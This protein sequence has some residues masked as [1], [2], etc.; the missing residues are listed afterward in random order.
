M[1]ESIKMLPCCSKKKKKR[2]G[3]E[4]KGA[5]SSILLS[6]P[7]I[8][9]QRMTRRSHVMAFRKARR[10]YRA[11]RKE[12][13]EKTKLLRKLYRERKARELARE[14]ARRVGREMAA[15]LLVE[16]LIREGSF[17][18]E[19]WDS[20]RTDGG[21]EFTDLI[22]GGRELEEEGLSEEIS[23]W[24][25]NHRGS[26]PTSH[27]TAR[28]ICDNLV[29][30][31][32]F[33]GEQRGKLRHPL[34]SKRLVSSIA[35]D[36]A[37]GLDQAEAADR[38]RVLCERL[39]GITRKQEPTV[40]R[41]ERLF[42]PSLL[43]DPV[44]Y[45]RSLPP[46]YRGMLDKVAPSISHT[47]V[48][49]SSTVVP[50]SHSPLR[51]SV[52]SPGLTLA[53]ASQG[54]L[55]S[56]AEGLDSCGFH[57]RPRHDLFPCLSST[58]WEKKL[59]ESNMSVMKAT[60][61]GVRVRTVVEGGV[62]LIRRIKFAR[63]DAARANV[64]EPWVQAYISDS[65]NRQ[66]IWLGLLS[67]DGTDFD[68]AIRS[69]EEVL[70]ICAII[71]IGTVSGMHAATIGHLH[72][73]KFAQ[74]VAA[75]LSGSDVADVSELT[76]EML[77]VGG[78]AISGERGQRVLHTRPALHRDRH[79]KSPFSQ[80][81]PPHQEVAVGRRCYICRSATHEAARCPDRHYNSRR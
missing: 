28:G 16:E 51:P 72:V 36:L 23:L 77:L 1:S 46:E 8:A 48:S 11:A 64:A 43:E 70:T 63:P 40:S 32:G 52:E 59:S 38:A 69:F 44:P 31:E 65:F 9:L 15:I 19:D 45:T 41:N 66:D 67:E 25:R 50:A 55:I 21:R 79:Q 54:S 14:E 68:M 6:N 78:G 3:G 80:G 27:Q 20:Y 22:D 4:R 57:K 42:K 75:R 17:T 30:H 24:V 56:V 60:V 5:D 29:L 61:A 12:L 49:T 39:F 58:K 2:M 62:E 81:P 74:Q 7:I 53:P 35:K 47:N 71:A 76:R 73:R 26:V 37:M 33:T 13:R 18:S 10:N 34:V